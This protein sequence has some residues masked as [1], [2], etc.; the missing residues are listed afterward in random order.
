M[1][2]I[3]NVNWEEHFMECKNNVD[4]LW[5]K[6]RSIFKAAEKA[7]IPRKIIKSGKRRC[8]YLLDEKKH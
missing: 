6:F 4:L 5:E 8:S 2:E 1:Q 3:L 7:C